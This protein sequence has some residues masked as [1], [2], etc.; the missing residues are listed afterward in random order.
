MK[1]IF[2][3][4]TVPF[5][6]ST[7]KIFLC[8]LYLIIGTFSLHA[9]NYSWNGSSSTAWGT[10]ANWTP[11]GV[12]GSSDNVTITNQTN[13]PQLTAD[14][15]IASLT[16]TSG[17][18]DLNGYSLTV[19]GN[20]TFTAGALNGTASTLILRGG[21]ALFG[22]T[23]INPVVDAV[24]NTLKFNGSTFNS[25]G[26]FEATTN[27]PG[28]SNGGCTFNDE[29][30][31]KRSYTG[32]GIMYLGYYAG[33]VYNANVTFIN[34]GT[35][36]INITT[37]GYSKFN[38]NVILESTASGGIIFGSTTGGV[39][40]L[41]SGKAISIGNGGFSAGTLVLRNF[42]QQGSTTQTL[43]LTSSGVC[44]VIDSKF[45]G[46]LNATAP[47][48]IIKGSTFNGTVHVTQNGNLNAT[49]DGGN[50]F[51]TSAYITNTGTGILRLD[52]TTPNTF[53][54][55]LY[56]NS[57]QN[58]IKLCM[59]GETN[60]YGDLDAQTSWV[61]L[62]SGT[63]KLVMKGNYPQ[64]LKSPNGIKNFKIDMSGSLSNRYVSLQGNTTISGTLEF[65]KGKIT[66]SSTNLLTLSATAS[67]TG[68]SDTGFVNGPIKKIGNTAFVFPTGKGTDYRAIE[69]SAP[70]GS[71]D[72]FTENTLTQ[73]KL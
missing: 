36:E 42:V 28:T 67:V 64:N 11:S 27:V 4:P 55:L 48:V 1:K 5:A 50:T 17:T 10:S 40:S 3:T 58:E 9:T 13:N 16:L 47:S 25:A 2:S 30:T 14:V 69:I 31:I 57:T 65:V 22:G 26:Y 15:T 72:A 73:R 8:T 51:N 12:P 66:T 46:Q 61:N 7:I 24:V 38:Q 32:S 53:Y 20:A 39:D 56:L 49:W 60:L 18:F 59:S 54:N 63:G 41:A 35:K 43:T 23:E 33:N 37:A 6:I 68:A 34:N 70:S 19:N 52:N 21:Q 71:S 45:D 62:L 29:V 44:N